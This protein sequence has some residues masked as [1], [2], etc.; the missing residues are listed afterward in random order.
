MLLVVDALV[1]PVARCPTLLHSL[2]DRVSLDTADLRTPRRGDLLAS[3]D[4]RLHVGTSRAMRTFA[5]IFPDDMEGVTC[6]F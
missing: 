1:M 5:G 4:P 3:V 2:A 6:R